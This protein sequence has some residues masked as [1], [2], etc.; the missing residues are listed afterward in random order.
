MTPDQG[1]NIDAGHDMIGASVAALNLTFLGLMGQKTG[2]M[3]LPLSL[4]CLLRVNYNAPWT[5]A[6]TLCVAA[7]VATSCLGAAAV[8]AEYCGKEPLADCT[9]GLMN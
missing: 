4:Y 1:I 3:A 9:V 8:F 2:K 5:R 6:N 7:N